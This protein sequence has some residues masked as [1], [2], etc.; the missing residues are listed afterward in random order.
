ML[1]ICEKTVLR[2]RFYHFTKPKHLILYNANYKD[3]AMPQLHLN[4]ETL[5]VDKC[6]CHIGFPIGNEKVKSR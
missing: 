4:G 5:Q 6:V 2:I 1:G 3:I